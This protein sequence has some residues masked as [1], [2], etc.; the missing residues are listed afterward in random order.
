MEFAALD[1]TD[2]TSI[3]NA[4]AEITGRFPELNVIVNNAGIQRVHDFSAAQPVDRTDIAAAVDE[5]GYTL[6]A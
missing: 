1:V 4:A 6:V 5:A 2:R 3:H